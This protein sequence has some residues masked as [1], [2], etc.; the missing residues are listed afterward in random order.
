MTYSTLDLEY[1][2][3]ERQLTPS[4]LESVTIPYTLLVITAM[5]DVVTE[6]RNRRFEFILAGIVRC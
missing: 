2:M 3:E 4:C 6:L 1:S 5:I